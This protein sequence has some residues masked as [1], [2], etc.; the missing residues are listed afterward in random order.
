M[1]CS[2]DT[3]V[4]PVIIVVINRSVATAFHITAFYAAVERAVSKD[5]AQLQVIN[6]VATS[7]TDGLD[8]TVPVANFVKREVRKHSAEK[9][10]V[11]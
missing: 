5:L 1:E 3:H 2:P 10:E 7:A 6:D 9:H 8:F 11:H 4:I